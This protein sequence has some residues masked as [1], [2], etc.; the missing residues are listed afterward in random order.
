MPSQ[1]ACPFLF[2]PLTVTLCFFAKLKN[3]CSDYE[4][5]RSWMLCRTEVSTTERKCC[6]E[7][8][9]H[10]EHIF[11]RLQQLFMGLLIHGM[12]P[13][14]FQKGTIIPLVKDRQ[15]DKGDLN[16]Y[17]GVTIAP[18]LSKI[19][20]HTLRIVVQSFLATSSYQFGFK[21]KSST[22]MAIY[23]LKE[24]NFYTSHAITAATLTAHFWMLQRRL[25][26]SSTPA[27][28]RSYNNAK[29]HSSS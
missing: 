25:I 16:N 1:T 22:S 19:F 18:I 6:D 2:F 5:L 17:R 7:L 20:E 4:D 23:Q 8:S 13:H 27:S 15:G 12:V 3:G 11:Y 9:I 29:F 14:Q 28:L 21:K 24:T 26:A 10:A